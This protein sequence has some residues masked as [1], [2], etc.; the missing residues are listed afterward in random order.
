MIDT[1][2][3]RPVTDATFA[4]EVLGSPLPVLVDFWTDWCPP[5][6]RLAPVLAELAAEYA[7]RVEFRSMDAEAEPDTAR[8][9]HVLAFPTL[10]LYRDGE[11]I[12]TVVGAQ[13]R[14]QLRKL[15]DVG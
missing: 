7:G 15:L 13:P 8:S 14:H 1:S 6:K 11:L 5:C 10:A 3:V 9:L 4:A 12:R 2:R